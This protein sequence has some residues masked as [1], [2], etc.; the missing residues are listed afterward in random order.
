MGN[1]ALI[2][3]SGSRSDVGYEIFRLS[4]CGFMLLVSRFLFLNP[5]K[6][7]LTQ[8]LYIYLPFV[9]VFASLAILTLIFFSTHWNQWRIY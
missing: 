5:L 1:L 6:H 9:F 7:G 4:Q 2:T 8:F 3:S